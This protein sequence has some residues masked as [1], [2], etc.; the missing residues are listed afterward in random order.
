MLGADTR[1]TAGSTVADKN[2]EKIHFIAPNIYCCGAGTAADTENVT[3]LCLNACTLLAGLCQPS[4]INMLSVRRD[5]LLHAG[6]PQIR[7]GEGVAGGDGSDTAEE[8]PLQ[9]LLCLSSV[10]KMRIL[11]HLPKQN[12]GL[13]HRYQGHVSAA[14][15]LG[16]VDFKGPHLFTVPNHGHG[17]QLTVHIIYNY[18]AFMWQCM[19]LTSSNSF[20]VDTQYIVEDV[21][22][23]H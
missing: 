18:F 15:V 9:V 14:L 6:A 4:Q 17:W 2:C 21:C 22:I 23:S 8:P 16:G 1:S 13:A 5:D 11:C 7:D 20:C 12:Y 19:V 10:E 3:G